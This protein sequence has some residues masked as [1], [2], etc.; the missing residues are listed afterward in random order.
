MPIRATIEA[1]FPTFTAIT[2]EVIRTS[3]THFGYEPYADDDLVTHWRS[4]RAR[5]PWLTLTDDTG[6]ALG[7]AK[8]GSWR[9]R[10]AYQW[11]CETTIYLATAVRGQGLGR[12]LYAS[13]LA[14]CVRLD[15]HSAVAG[16]TLP[17]AASVR[18]HESLG[19]TPVGVVQEAG[20]KFERWWDVGFWQKRL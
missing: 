8:A 1:D 3:A 20:N 2:N 15:F 19:F 17:N 11:T 9:E 7:Y 4:Q 18:L 5:F 13:L 12:P 6:A 16:I 14:E 10:A